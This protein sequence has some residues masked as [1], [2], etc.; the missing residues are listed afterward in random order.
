MFEKFGEFNSVEE[1]NAAAEGFL[2]EGDIKSLYAL[3]EENGIDKEDAE[4]YVNGDTKVFATLAMAAFGR[5]SV[6]EKEISKEKNV[7]ERMI[8]KQILEMV[9]SICTEHDMA[10]AVMKKGKNVDVIFQTM[11]KGAEKHKSGNCGVSCGT[12]R[13]LCEIIKAYY[14]GSEKKLNERIEQLYK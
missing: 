1:L 14:L 10:T 5:L 3:A 2:K 7:M 12:D 11:K 8:K 6:Q 9:K 4:D 13:D